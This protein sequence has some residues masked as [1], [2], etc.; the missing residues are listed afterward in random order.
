M[1]GNDSRYTG[2]Y[3]IS[4]EKASKSPNKPVYKLE[5]EDKYIYYYPDS[6]G[7]L[8]GSKSDLSGE[9][10]GDSWYQSKF[11]KPFYFSNLYC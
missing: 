7:W 8:V 5:G 3:L 2:S 6:D 1:S 11:L 10:E 4:E 9:N